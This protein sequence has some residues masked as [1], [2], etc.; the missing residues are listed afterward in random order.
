MKQ[1][2]ETLGSVL[3]IFIPIIVLGGIVYVLFRV[4]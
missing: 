1:R 4:L 3:M 2:A